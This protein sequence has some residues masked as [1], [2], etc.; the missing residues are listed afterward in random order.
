MTQNNKPEWF[1]IAENDGPA[2]TPKASKGLPV[3]AVL[4]TALILGVGAVVSQVQEKS[5]AIAVETTSVHSASIKN[6]ATPTSVARQSESTPSAQITKIVASTTA[7]VPSSDVVKKTPTVAATTNT[8]GLQN[9]A[10]AKLP[11]KSEDDEDDHDEHSQK[12]NHDDDD[13]ED[14]QGDND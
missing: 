12:R 11:T 8:S 13:E 4:V 1:E 7:I 14:E 6:T 10:I 5:P 9:P 3:A 2:A